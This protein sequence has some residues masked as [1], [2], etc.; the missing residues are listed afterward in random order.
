MARRFASCDPLR[1]RPTPQRDQTDRKSVVEG[2]SGDLGGRRIIKKKKQHPGGDG[3]FRRHR[4]GERRVHAVALGRGRWVTA[5]SGVTV[6]ASDRY[7]T[8]PSIFFKQK[9]AYE[10][11]R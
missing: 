6:E 9:T 11:H 5:D 8:S 1:I 2:K 4:A 10:M 7:R 3:G